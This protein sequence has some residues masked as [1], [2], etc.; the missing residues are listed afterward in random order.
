LQLIER[1][2]ELLPYMAV[3]ITVKS[4]SWWQITT[5]SA[6]NSFFISIVGE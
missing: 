5:V 1:L 6:N 3:K 4:F 2:D